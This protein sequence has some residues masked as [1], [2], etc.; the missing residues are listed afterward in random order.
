MTNSPDP[1]IHEFVRDPAKFLTSIDGKKS[2]VVS[3]FHTFDGQRPPA[4][5]FP[6]QGYF[7]FV[8]YHSEGSQ[9]TFEIVYHG[10]TAGTPNTIQAYNLHYTGGAQT[11]NRP[12]FIDIPKKVPENTLLFTGTLSGCSVIVTNLNRDT[13]RVFHDSRVNSSLL[14]DNV[15]MAIDYTSYC[16]S[17]RGTA[18]VFMQ[19]RKGHWNMFA[20]LQVMKGGGMAPMVQ[21]HTE[22]YQSPGQAYFPLIVME[23][24]SYNAAEARAKFD[25]RRRTNREEL[26]RMAAQFL[27]KTPIPNESDGDFVPDDISFRNP[28]VKHSQAIRNVINAA[29][30]GTGEKVRLDRRPGDDIEQFI[31]ATGE[32]ALVE[33]LLQWQTV[34]LKLP[35]VPIV[36]ESQD[37]DWV[38]LWLKQKERRGFGAV[39]DIR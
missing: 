12:A 20:Q 31:P 4:G 5:G 11:S 7:K 13:Y 33:S 3:T 14:Y 8:L 18:C 19:Y 27:P 25:D 23:P 6:K 17:S 38:Y 30:G 15:E 22:M 10:P 9:R 24:G 34:N 29:P 26:R 16:F 35:L 21:R 28:A 37:L 2:T 36:E 39:V 32:G 1:A